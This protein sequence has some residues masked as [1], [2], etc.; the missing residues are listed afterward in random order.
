MYTNGLLSWL[1]R[2]VQAE[3]LFSAG[4]LFSPNF[5]RRSR[6]SSVVSPVIMACLSASFVFNEGIV[7]FIVVFDPEQA[8]MNC[9]VSLLPEFIFLVY[10]S[11]LAEITQ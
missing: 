7:G 9:G 2:I 11:S 3:T 6:T 8:G 10:V 4:S 5:A 1:T